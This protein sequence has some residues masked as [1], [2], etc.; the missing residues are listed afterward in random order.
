MTDKTDKEIDEFINNVLVAVQMVQR[1]YGMQFIAMMP[2]IFPGE[3]QR[4]RFIVSHRNDEHARLTGAI[5]T[6]DNVISEATADLFNKCQAGLDEAIS[7]I[8]NR[9]DTATT[10]P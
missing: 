1:I 6:C 3:K 5:R 2:V 7:D 10:T 9:V 4:M 8:R